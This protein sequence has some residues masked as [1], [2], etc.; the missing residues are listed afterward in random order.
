MPRMM[1][2]PASE[3]EQEA[4]KPKTL[5]KKVGH[6]FQRTTT[7]SNSRIQKAAQPIVEEDVEEIDDEKEEEEQENGTEASDEYVVEKIIDHYCDPPNP[8]IYKVRWQGF[9]READHT[10]ETKE[11]LLGALECLEVYWTAVGGE[12]T[13]NTTKLKK[14]NRSSTG[15]AL[16]D[17]DDQAGKKARLTRKSESDLNAKATSDSQTNGAKTGGG[18]RGRK[19][20]VRDSPARSMSDERIVDKY[21]L[22][23]PNPGAWE[24]EIVSIETIE[25]A[26]NDEKYALLRCAAKDEKG[27]W[28]SM[29][30]KLSTVY[31]AAPQQMLRFYES[32]LVFTDKPAAEK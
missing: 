20:K 2:E 16:I 32:H 14:R 17:M 4:L 24:N 30:A 29:K 28:R 12:P 22:P 31:V 19:P 6:V 15:A 27:A 3:S 5:P 18:K 7:K 8:T 23:P 25:G 10:W 9:P 26:P 11:N 21:Q 13:T 1:S